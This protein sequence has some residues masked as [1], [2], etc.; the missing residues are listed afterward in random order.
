LG[1]RTR[2]LGALAPETSVV[3]LYHR[4]PGSAVFSPAEPATPKDMDEFH[5]LRLVVKGLERRRGATASRLILQ[6]IAR[7][8]CVQAYASIRE[9]IAAARATPQREARPLL[10]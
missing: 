4:S 10:H 1:K 6:G 7:H 3:R 2:F 9:L 5:L 8:C